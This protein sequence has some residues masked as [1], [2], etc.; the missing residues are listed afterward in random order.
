MM[1]AYGPKNPCAHP[2]GC[3]YL[4]TNDCERVCQAAADR[5]ASDT[6]IDKPQQPERRP[7][8]AVAY[9]VGGHLYEVLLPGDAS[10]STVNGALVIEHSEQV[11]GIVRIKPVRTEK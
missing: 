1:R 6:A 3:A 8:Y 9:S 5:L 7:P 11:L 2:G 10:A 4:L